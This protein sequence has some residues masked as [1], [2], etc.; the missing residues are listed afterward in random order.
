MPDLQNDLQTRLVSEKRSD[1]KKIQL[2]GEEKLNIQ[3]QV[4]VCNLDY[5]FRCRRLL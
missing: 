1:K 3:R 2:K 5:C 4:T